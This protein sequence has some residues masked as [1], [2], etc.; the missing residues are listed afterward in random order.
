MPLY[1]DS[2][3]AQI[4]ITTIL[5]ILVSTNLIGNTIV[6]L[7]IILY[8]DMRTPT[9][10]L[11]LNLAVADAM[12]AWFIAPRFILIHTFEH[13][14]GQAGTWVCKLLTGG[15][16]TWTGGAAS[17]FTLVI[18][19]PLSW[20]G[21]ILLNIPLFLTIHFDKKK[22]FCMEYWHPHDW[23][24]KAY[25]SI[26]FF[27]A[28]L[29]PIVLMTV[30]YSKVVYALWFKKEDG[31]V[32]NM[33]QNTRQG[34]I[35]VRKRVTK[36][37][38]VVSVIYGLCW[39]PNLIIYAL[40][41]FSPSQNYGDVTYITSIVLV[42]FNSTVNPFIY[43]FV[44]QKFQSKVKSLLCCGK[45]CR[46]LI[47]ELSESTSNTND[48]NDTV[49][50]LTMVSTKPRTRS[51]VSTAGGMQKEGQKLEQQVAFCQQTRRDRDTEA[52]WS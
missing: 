14:D 41:Y 9:N 26:W 31:T 3:S 7:V 23:L 34:V 6:A 19:I 35:R 37:V 16:L 12:V 8:R 25:S 46:N 15:N 18:V 4:G 28:G 30:L 17:V 38:L 11:L 45:T 44:N 40:N 51:P 48:P 2:D 52:I 20:I 39:L 36:M 22:N 47:G 49:I 21:A 10:F 5:S 1:T 50:Q 42:T 43:V 24:P 13:P 33:T 27:V 29:I 32:K